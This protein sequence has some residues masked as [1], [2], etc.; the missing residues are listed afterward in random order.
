MSGRV[1]ERAGAAGISDGGGRRRPRRR[2]PLQDRTPIVS[3]PSIKIPPQQ[4]AAT[5]QVGGRA[6]GRDVVQGIHDASRKIG[7]DFAY[8]LAKANQE[9][10]LRPDAANQRGSARGLFQFTNQTWLETVRKH[11]AKHG[12]ADLA[13][14]IERDGR[15]RLGV[16]DAETEAR[17]LDLRRDPRISSLMAAEFASDNRRYLEY[18]LGRAAS[19]TDIYTAHFL[20]PGGAVTFL[21]AVDRS[22]GKAAADVL[23][24]AA[25]SNPSLF[26]V[27]G[28]A[29]SLAELRG[30]LHGI[31]SD[32]M[33]RFGG[34]QSL[35]M[36]PPP[37]PSAKPAPP[38]PEDM[39]GATRLAQ[40]ADRPPPAPGARPLPPDWEDM[41]RITLAVTAAPPPPPVPGAR[42]LPPGYEDMGA[43]RVAG[44]EA[45]PLPPGARPD[46]PVRLPPG[47]E[48]AP[49]RVAEADPDDAVA[50]A[51]AS[52]TEAVEDAGRA[53]GVVLP[54]AAALALA[55]LLDETSPT[56]PTPPMPGA[57]RAPV[58][59]PSG[60]MPNPPLF[61][62]ESNALL[63][64]A[65]AAR[66][67]FDRSD[68]PAAYAAVAAASPAA[69]VTQ[70][71][72]AA[73]MPTEAPVAVAFV[74]DP[75]DPT[76]PREVLAVGRPVSAAPGESRVIMGM[77]G[78]EPPPPTD[79][80][81]AAD[82]NQQMADAGGLV[83]GA[84]ALI[85]DLFGRSRRG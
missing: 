46:A 56:P 13:A 57:D 47:T 85:A 19:P 37:P 26:Y 38:P 36:A 52:V 5:V 30:L 14:L 2:A 3:G 78:L 79:A 43:T 58:S 74:A 11:G 32:A 40:R 33:R 77:P 50:R 35:V 6:V 82:P 31:I 80:A 70:T 28:R 67:L 29:R 7:V 34:V 18:K 15:G 49:T 62:V 16:A 64:I 8:M 1:G 9:S 10:G 39:G 63:H 60:T 83:N 17:L 54:D 44:A 12:L 25:K 59:A 51:V 75:P 68:G 76:A 73:V 66:P 71:A 42:P 41:G 72:T 61:G 53:R 81:P 20:G 45:L 65:R 21:N 23:P 27:G 24:I 69:E 48:T 22:P 4:L 55:L 84:A